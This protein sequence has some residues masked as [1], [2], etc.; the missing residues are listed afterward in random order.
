MELTSFSF[1]MCVV[2]RQNWMYGSRSDARTSRTPSRIVAAKFSAYCRATSPMSGSG[3]E[4][5]LSAATDGTP[6]R[7]G[8]RSARP[9]WSMCR[10]PSPAT[11]C[12]NRHVGSD[13]SSSSSCSISSMCF[14]TWSVSFTFTLLS[15][16]SPGWCVTNWPRSRGVFVVSPYVNNVCVSLRSPPACSNSGTSDAS[17]SL[18]QSVNEAPTRPPRTGSGSGAGSGAGSRAAAAPRCFCRALVAVL[19]DWHKTLFFACCMRA[20]VPRGRGGEWRDGEREGDGFY[21]TQPHS[22]SARTRNE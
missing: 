8:G 13:S 17:M 18:S 4:T 11:C 9:S 12:K 5:A 20:R 2:C 22:A 21:R 7:S 14:H 19:L 10:F 6:N 1:E 15:Q 3:T 16:G